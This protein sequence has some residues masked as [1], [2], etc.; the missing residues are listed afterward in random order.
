MTAFTSSAAYYAILSDTPARLEREGPLLLDLLGRAPGQRVVDLACG[1]GLHAEFL[2]QH[3]A[4][5]T[6]FDVSSE[7]IA[8]AAGHRPHPGATY[9]VGDM[10]RLAQG[11]WDLAL[12]LGNSLAA[13]DAVSEIDVVFDR[14]FAGL[15]PGGLFLCQVTNP[16]SRDAREPR[17]RVE[18]KRADGAEIVAVKTLAPHGE[19]TLLSLAFFARRGD[20]YDHVAETA[21]LLHVGRD[22]LVAAAQ[23]AGLDVLDVWGG[24]D[25]A[26]FDPDCSPDAVCVFRRPSTVAS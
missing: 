4:T 23:Q 19:R 24:Y 7:M 8:H 21:V 14:V 22:T 2:A 20:R 9:A 11:P 26:A 15:A 13:L 16:T 25:R 6:A 10:R 12:C 17:H 1:T 18:R 5:V 3:G